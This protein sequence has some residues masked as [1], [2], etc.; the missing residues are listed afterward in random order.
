MT[1]CLICEEI[2]R[3]YA[4]LEAEEGAPAEKNRLLQLQRAHDARVHAAAA[5]RK[6]PSSKHMRIA[7]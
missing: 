2:L 5:P 6:K 3:A 4:E 1:G 7:A